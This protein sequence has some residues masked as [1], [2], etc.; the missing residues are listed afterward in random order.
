MVPPA[1]ATQYSCV[2]GDLADYLDR[3]DHLSCK[4]LSIDDE[5]GGCRGRRCQENTHTICEHKH[6]RTKTETGCFHSEIHFFKVIGSL[7]DD[8]LQYIRF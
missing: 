8:S 3:M 4:E 6:F 2:C 5:L 1:V 7:F